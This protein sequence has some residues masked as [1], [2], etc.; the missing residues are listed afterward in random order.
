MQLNE[1]NFGHLRKKIFWQFFVVNYEYISVAKSR[2][3]SPS[4]ST[5]VKIDVAS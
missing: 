1:V 2:F 5:K 3:V 4:V